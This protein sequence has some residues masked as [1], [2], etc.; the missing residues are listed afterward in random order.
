VPVGRTGLPEEVGRVVAALVEEGGGYAT[1]AVVTVDGGL[2]L[3]RL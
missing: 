2:S 1:G 3:G